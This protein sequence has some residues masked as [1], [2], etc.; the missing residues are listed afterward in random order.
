MEMPLVSV[1]PLRRMGISCGRPLNFES[2]RYAVQ[3]SNISSIASILP[4]RI[5]RLADIAYNL[6]WCWNSDTVALWNAVDPALWHDSHHNPIVL[7]RSLSAQRL[8]D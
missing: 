1:P 8:L 7:L 3:G 4:E 6:W 5:A 2:K